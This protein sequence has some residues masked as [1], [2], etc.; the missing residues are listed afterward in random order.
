MPRLVAAV[1]NNRSQLVRTYPFNSP[2]AAARI[3]ALAMLADGLVC[4]SV[5]EADG[6]VAPSESAV[7][8]AAVEHWGLQRS[9]LPRP[10][11]PVSVHH[12]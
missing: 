3:V 5:A 11:S 6:D 4:L 7:L 2:Q 9:M 1:A 10:T 12:A 8:A